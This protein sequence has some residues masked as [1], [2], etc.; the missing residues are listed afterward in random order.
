VTI[1]DEFVGGFRGI[2]AANFCGALVL[3][4]RQFENIVIS[5]FASLTGK[6]DA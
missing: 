1:L 3:G 4:Y 6:A 2:A 5:A